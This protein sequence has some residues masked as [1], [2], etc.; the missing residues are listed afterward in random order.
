MLIGQPFARKL[1]VPPMT[2][3]QSHLKKRAIAF[4]VDFSHFTGRAWNKGRPSGRKVPLD[5]FLKQNS[6]AKSHKIRLRLIEEGIKES[7]CECCKQTEWLGGPIPLELDHINGDHFDNRLENLC[8]LC[9][10][11]HAL[12]TAVSHRSE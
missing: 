3:S 10:N 5:Q 6:Y 12:K 1:G 7:K 9:P 2:G 4:G 8:I 11:C